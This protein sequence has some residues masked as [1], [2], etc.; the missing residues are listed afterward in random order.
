MAHLISELSK[1]LLIILFLSYTFEC[2]HVFRYEHKLAK[3]KS[4]YAFQ[5]YLLPL[6]H[7]DGYLVIFLHTNDYKMIA[8]YFMQV[9]LFVGIYCVYRFCFQKGSQLL[10]NNMIML[11]VI[12]FII[13]TR[14]SFEQ[15]LKQFFILLFSALLS[16]AIPFIL[17]KEGRFRNFTWLYA[18]IG[19]AS[20]A[21]V[22]ILG[23]VSYG[24]KL[25]ISIA[26][27]SIQ[28]SEFIKI[29]YV[30][31][32]ASLLYKSASFK[33]V[34][35]VSVLAGLHVLILVASKDLGAALLFF[36]VYLFMIYVASKKVYYLV[37]GMAFIAIAGVAGYF[38]FYHVQVRV[39]AWLNPLKDIDNKGYQMS[40]SLFGIGTGGWFGM[41]LYQGIPKKIPVVSQ[42]FIFSAISE[43]F[44]GIFA[45]SLILVCFSC[46]LMMIIVAMQMKDKFYSLVALGLSTVYAFQVVL[47][48]GGV[49]KFIPSTGVTLPFVSYGG[50]SLLSSMLIFGII[51]ALYIRKAEE[52]TSGIKEVPHGK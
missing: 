46:F 41:G 30:F 42:D 29:S 45:L 26:G 32:I 22:L 43:E 4:I 16:F 28:P 33:Q 20:L 19:I 17:T 44:G 12:S 25:S 35:I 13:L 50:S 7:L 15:A 6:I 40:Q 11:L 27:I 23:A 48:I 37:G 3:Q 14:I 18:G 52:R 38:L 34:A 5:R 51:Q 24:A 10:L 47:T 1:Y 2:F 9:I 36:M 49:T 31:M 39:E 21:L 8:F